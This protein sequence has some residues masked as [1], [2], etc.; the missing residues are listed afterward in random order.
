MRS[1]REVENS[2]ITRRKKNP[3]LHFLVNYHNLTE[4]KNTEH[5][6]LRQEST[7]SK[8]REIHFCDIEKGKKQKHLL[9]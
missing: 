6:N 7:K 9:L 1:P 8:L 4:K 5:F 3:H 2:S